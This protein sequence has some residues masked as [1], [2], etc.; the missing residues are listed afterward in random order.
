MTQRSRIPG[1]SRTSL[2]SL[3]RKSTTR[4]IRCILLLTACGQT[5]GQTTLNMPQDLIRLGIATANMTPNQQALDAGP[6]FLKAVQYAQNNQI[7]RVIAD[8][9][10]YYFLSLLEQH[11]LFGKG[12]S[13]IDAHLLASA[14]LSGCKL[15]TVDNP[16]RVAAAQLKV[17]YSYVS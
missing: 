17:G 7:G 16:L 11:R 8:T 14:R 1:V 6:L 12:L 4:L 10:S 15:W 9:G 3:G 2:D 5:F 13:W